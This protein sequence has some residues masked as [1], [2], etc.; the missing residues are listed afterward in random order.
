MGMSYRR[1]NEW[2]MC[3][4]VPIRTSI[5]ILLFGFTMVIWGISEILGFDFNFWA[6]IAIFFGAVIL[7]NSFT[8][9]KKR[10]W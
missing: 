1:K 10:L 9:S 8:T 5:W 2:Q 3:F 4:G 7:Y 6:L